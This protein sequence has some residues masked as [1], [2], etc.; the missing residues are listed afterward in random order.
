MALLLNIQVD[1]EVQRALHRST[2]RGRPVDG[3]GCFTRLGPLG[4]RIIPLNLKTQ[5]R[6]W[7]T[8]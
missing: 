5:R 2:A 8:G 1:C 4:R 6:T 3:A 7:V